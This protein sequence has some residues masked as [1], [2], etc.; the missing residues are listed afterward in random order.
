MA[1]VAE[2]AGARQTGRNVPSEPTPTS[3][4]EILEGP[5][6]G[7]EALASVLEPTPHP[8][9]ATT[10]GATATATA[11]AA[12][13]TAKAKT[14]TK[15]GPRTAARR[16][17]RSL[18]FPMPSARTVLIGMAIGIVVLGALVAVLVA[19]RSAGV[20]A[21]SAPATETSLR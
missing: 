2:A 10:A 5:T 16:V 1:M 8:A 19:R 17:L 13:A 15:E 18:P 6:P 12:K 4:M 21:A 20:T 7:P 9:T 14:K 3:P 11:A